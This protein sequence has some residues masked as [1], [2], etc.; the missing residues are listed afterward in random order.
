MA[1]LLIESPLAERLRAMAE[2]EHRSVESLLE[3]MVER[4]GGSL[5]V[6]EI[7]ARL[8]DLP[9]ITVP[10]DDPDDPPIT[11][12]ELE[13]IAQRAGEAGSLS[14]LIIDERKQGW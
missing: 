3:D 1:G 5:T 13:T 12:E 14:A 2:Q 4:Y 9:G 7:N 6:K 8:R 10:P 11:E